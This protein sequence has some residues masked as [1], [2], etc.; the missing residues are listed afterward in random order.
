MG[1]RFDQVHA[2]D[3]EHMR[4]LRRVERSID[5]NHD[6]K[7]RGEALKVLSSHGFDDYHA[8]LNNADNSS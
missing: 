4:R 3:D 2:L 8:L 6:R 1:G 5:G 7:T